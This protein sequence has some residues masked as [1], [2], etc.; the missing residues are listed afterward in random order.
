MTS[1]SQEVKDLF[2]PRSDLLKL[3]REAAK[4][5]NHEEWAEYKTL[6]KKF[7]GERRFVKRTFEMEYPARLTKARL[8]LIN[9]AGAVKR[10]L[11]LKVFGADAFDKTEINRRARIEVRTA[12]HNDLARID[13][14]ECDALRTILNKSQNRTMQREKPI[15]DFQKAVD[16]RTGPERRAR[17]RS[18]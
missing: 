6:S 2:Q 18:R 1:L 3:R 15:K 12:H 9:Q 7:D 10:R 4:V 5:L 8:R 13:K 17:S 16:R 14:R 11:V